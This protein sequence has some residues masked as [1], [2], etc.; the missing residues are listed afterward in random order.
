MRVLIT[1]GARR[2]GRV[3]VLEFLKNNYEVIFT[4]NKSKKEAFELKKIGAV[5]VK[6]NLLHQTKKLIDF[7]GNKKIDVLINNASI[8][9]PVKIE[10]LKENNFYDFFKI[11]FFVPLELA[12]K[13]KK[14]LKGG[15]IINIIDASIHTYRKNFLPYIS[16]KVLLMYL[17]KFLSHYLAPYIRVSGVSPGAVLFPENYTFKKKEAIKNMNLMEKEGSPEDIA[18]AC[19]FIAKNGFIN[20]EIIEVSGGLKCHSF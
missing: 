20:S 16:S 5:P 9:Y 12:L 18:S 10:G 3:L 8:F 14:N 1:G 4:Y 11:H 19:L 17:T 2:I 6:C 7:I 15:C 13:L